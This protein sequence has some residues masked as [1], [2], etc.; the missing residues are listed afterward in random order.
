MSCCS[1]IK[2]CLKYDYK[3]V[4]E[5]TYKL[6]SKLQQLSSKKLA[7]LYYGYFCEE[8]IDSNI[9]AATT[10]LKSLNRIKVSYLHIGKYCLPEGVVQ[11]IIEKAIKFVGKESC[12]KNRKDIIVDGS[13]INQ[14]LLSGPR[15]VTYD[16]WN[17]FSS[18][19]CGN[20]GF[21]LK[22]EKQICDITFDIT[23]NILSCNLLYA[24]QIKKE[25]CDLGYKVVKT[26]DECK[27]EYK[28]LI[29]KYPNCN[30]E[31]K[32]YLSFVNDHQLTYPIFKEVYE[33]GL[34]LAIQ[35]GDAFVCTP[36]NNYKL[37]EISPNNLQE[38]L[39]AGYVVS[40]NKH[41]LKQDY[42]KY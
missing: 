18:F 40:L 28:L 31:Y 7:N 8:D 5:L 25:L 15:C 13:Q 20:L 26:K 36:I 37:T 29:E 42:T 19:L 39:N 2:V 3:D 34:T 11:A 33:S 22:V 32:A 12:P 24:L 35:E 21:Q 41:D 27:L 14:Y 30:L 17:K 23:R 16:T 1:E 4:D 10:L 9:N 6:K 38:L